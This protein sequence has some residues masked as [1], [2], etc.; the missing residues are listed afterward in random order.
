MCRLQR[1][2]RREIADMKAAIVED[3]KVHRELLSLY[4]EEWGKTRQEEIALWQYE[5]AE[6]FLFAWEEMEFDVV[7][8][9]IQMPGMNG[10]ELA[11]RIRQQNEKIAIIFTTGIDTYLQEGYEVE[12][13]YYLLKPISR[14]RVEK[15]LEKVRKKP[16]AQEY[17]I[18]HLL[19]DETEKLLIAQINFVEARKHTC[20]VCLNGGREVAVRESLSQMEQLLKE[21]DFIKSHRS[22]LCS[23]NRIRQIGKEQIFFDDAC[24]A[25]VSRRLYQSVNQ[26]FIKF[27]QKDIKYERINVKNTKV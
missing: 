9:D 27:Y 22:Y 5:K 2:P 11:R 8:L 10:M 6:A 25:P 21:K 24:T 14:E 18:V 19:T 23:L 16:A 4:I 3:E 7:F 15:C 17:L 13:L 12:A 26:E 20:V 1:L